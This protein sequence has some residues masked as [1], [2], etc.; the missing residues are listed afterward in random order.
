MI[1]SAHDIEAGH[2]SAF[3]LVTKA[4]RT[5]ETPEPPFTPPGSR[6]AVESSFLSGTVI[7]DNNS[8]GAR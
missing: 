8:D 6:I 1:R 3:Y 7:G 2:Q 5:S 4:A